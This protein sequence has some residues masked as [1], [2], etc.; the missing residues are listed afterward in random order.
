MIGHC[1]CHLQVVGRALL[2]VGDKSPSHM[3]TCFERY[4]IALRGLI[5]QYDTAAAHMQAGIVSPG[6]LALL[7]VRSH[8]TMV[9]SR[10]FICH[11]QLTVQYQGFCLE[12]LCFC[13][14]HRT[15][16]CKHACS[17][18][19]ARA[20]FIGT[21]VFY[22]YLFELMCIHIHTYTCE[23]GSHAPP[24]SHCW[25]LLVLLVACACSW[26]VTFTQRCSRSSSWHWTACCTYVSL[27]P[28]QL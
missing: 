13:S 9:P 25:M 28:P 4:A 6:Q 27:T 12:G 20:L 8:H 22:A 15:G 2:S 11:L 23:H 5:S 14:R 3:H 17:D 10:N 7:E 1:R 24:C 26:S 18:Q 19:L 21:T 16:I